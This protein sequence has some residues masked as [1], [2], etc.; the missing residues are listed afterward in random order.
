MSQT[1]VYGA[2]P[3]QQ[4]SKRVR[5]LRPVV[6]RPPDGQPARLISS[7]LS[8][9]GMFIR[10]P[11]PPAEG[12]T[13][14]VALEARGRALPFAHGEVVFRLP[15]T[16]ARML[17]CA[18]GFGL[19]FT[20]LEGKSRAL[21][22]HLL[23]VCPVAQSESSVPFPTAPL[24]HTP[25]E[26]A[27]APHPRPHA[28]RR[29]L[30][31]VWRA[32]GAVSILCAAAAL[33]LA[34]MPRHRPA[35]PPVAEEPEATATPP[36]PAERGEPAPELTV[37]PV[38]VSEAPAKRTEPAPD[39][40]A[41]RTAPEPVPESPAAPEPVPD[42]PVK[43]GR[44]A[45]LDLSPESGA[46]ASLRFDAGGDRLNI[47]V[48]MRGRSTLVQAVA[49]RSPPGLILDLE[50]EVPRSALKL[51]GAGNVRHVRFLPRT[52]GTRVVV[53][54]SRA[55]DRVLRE[56]ELVTLFYSRRR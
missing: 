24:L 31:W 38:P 28:P 52:G 23:N 36:D 14:E 37:T 53:T 17:G 16:Q 30:R 56:G 34:A 39:A 29:W 54:L 44:G 13:V 42:T 48:R 1:H 55:V 20:R 32:L 47:R 25:I 51:S 10:T 3:S 46:V 8:G 45:M 43:S 27:A 12:T 11:L 4:R 22:D 35:P 26:S 50:G 19:R 6:V 15:E 33:A 5:F 41:K 2:S 9:G 40:P 7:N 18:P 49:L 21:V